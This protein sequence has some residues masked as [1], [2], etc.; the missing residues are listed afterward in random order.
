MEYSI[1]LFRC[2]HCPLYISQ[3]TLGLRFAFTIT[4]SKKYL[5]PT[6][7]IVEAVPALSLEP[8]GAVGA[9]PARLALAAPLAGEGGATRAV[10]GARGGAALD[11][12]VPPVPARHAET[13]AVLTLAVQRAPGTRTRG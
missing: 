12:A 10:A 1:Y 9:V 4:I 8:G 5:L 7:V 11:G 13:R 2:P 6:S 3:S